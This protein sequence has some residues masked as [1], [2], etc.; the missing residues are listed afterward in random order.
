MYKFAI[1]TFAQIASPFNLLQ[2][3]VMMLKFQSDNPGKRDNKNRKIIII[4][5][6]ILDDG[7]RKEPN[8]ELS[9]VYFR[10]G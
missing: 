5:N 3:I 9:Q 6:R 7:P 10:D 2:K 4:K 8:E 1:H